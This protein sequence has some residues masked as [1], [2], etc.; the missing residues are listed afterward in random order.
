MN[1]QIPTSPKLEPAPINLIQDRT[2]TTL[3]NA[4]PGGQS[5]LNFGIQANGGLSRV[6]RGVPP[7]AA[8]PRLL[9]P[10]AAAASHPFR[11]NQLSLIAWWIPTYITFVDPYEH[12][13]LGNFNFDHPLFQ[14]LKGAAF[15]LGIFA[16]VA[17]LFACLGSKLG[18]CL[19][20]Q[21]ALPGY[22]VNVAFSLAGI[23][24]YA[25]LCWFGNG[26]AIWILIASLALLPFFWK[27]WRL[28]LAAAAIVLPLALTPASVIWTP[29]YRVSLKPLSLPDNKGNLYPMGQTVEVNHDGIFGAYNFS[30][31]FVGTLPPEVKDRL[32]DY[33]NSAQLLSHLRAAVPA[34]SHPGLGGRE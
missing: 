32:L 26:P 14:M 31:E 7:R 22:S 3:Q 27:S 18:A 10:R 29:Y 24:L 1:W 4:Q 6:G 9:S 15:V 20:G 30:D 19:N 25:A 16:L 34:S 12:Y 2:K 8:A 23:L 28:A 21:E 33:Y 17:A 11:C 13:L 5:T